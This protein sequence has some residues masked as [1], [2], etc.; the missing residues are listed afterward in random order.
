MQESRNGEFLEITDG[1]FDGDFAGI[2]SVTGKLNGTLDCAS[3]E[4]HAVSLDGV[5][6]AAGLPGGTFEAW[7]DGMHDPVASS[8]AGTYG[9]LS[10]AGNA[11]GTFHVTRSP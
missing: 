1:V 3:G 7:W 5:W 9:S 8:I 6:F 2:I 4:F 10:P 11:N